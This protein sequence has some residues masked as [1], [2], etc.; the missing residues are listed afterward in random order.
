MYEEIARQIR[1][2]AKDE[3]KIAMFHFQV[4]TN[5]EA[6]SSDDPLEFCRRVGV[7]ASYVTEFHKML[8]LAQII[9]RQGLRLR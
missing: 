3:S 7:P 9:R 1:E 5:A 4:L 6:L 8:K 2:A